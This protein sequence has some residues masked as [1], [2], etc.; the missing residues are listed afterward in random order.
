MH[1]EG[2][3]GNPFRGPFGPSQASFP[4]FLPL[5]YPSSCSTRPPLPRRESHLLPGSTQPPFPTKSGRHAIHAH[6]SAHRVDYATLSPNYVKCVQIDLLCQGASDL[7]G[8]TLLQPSPLASGFSFLPPVHDFRPSLTPLSLPVHQVSSLPYTPYT[9]HSR[10][11]SN[12]TFQVLPSLK[13]S[14]RHPCTNTCI[15][16]LIS[17][18]L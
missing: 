18:C 11:P 2:T 10:D 6:T 7:A 5:N 14:P 15:R 13:I 12:S 8:V 1:G 17:R 9:A 16:S 4:R 3:Q